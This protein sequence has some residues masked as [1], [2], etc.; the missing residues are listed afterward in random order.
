MDGQKVASVTVH[1]L[2][3]EPALYDLKAPAKDGKTPEP[4]VKFPAGDYVFTRTY[5]PAPAGMPEPAGGPLS[6]FGSGARSAT[7]IQPAAAA[8]AAVPV[9]GGKACGEGKCG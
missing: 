2:S 7:S 6:R 8:P 5:A 1:Y 9:P 3:S 4:I